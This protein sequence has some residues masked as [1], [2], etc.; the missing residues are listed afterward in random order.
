MRLNDRPRGRARIIVATLAVLPIMAGLGGCVDPA[1][2]PQAGRLDIR[3]A[4]AKGEIQSPKMAAMAVASIDGAPEAI[5]ARLKHDMASEAANREITITD[6]ALARYFVRGYLDAYPT[7]SGTSVHYVWDV[8]DTT[9]HRTQRLDDA[10]DLP[11]AAGDDPWSG[12]S[13]EVLANI[14]ARSA[15]DLAVFL[16]KTPEAVADA[17]PVPSGAAAN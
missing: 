9:K 2:G 3:A 6:P 7:E 13:D 17:T 15:D 1:L 11:A 8:F 16:G 4:I 10:V 14:A 5:T 12:V